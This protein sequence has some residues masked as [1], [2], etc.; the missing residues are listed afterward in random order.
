MKKQ[1]LSKFKDWFGTAARPE[2]SFSPLGY[3]AKVTQTVGQGRSGMILLNGE[4]WQAEVLAQD[5]S[6]L[7]AEIGIGEYVKVVKQ[8]GLKLYVVP[9]VAHYNYGW[10]LPDKG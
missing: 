5:G 7:P 4:L 6:G 3:T 8:E 2:H 1:W 9:T 10:E